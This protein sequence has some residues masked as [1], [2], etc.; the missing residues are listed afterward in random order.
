M[1][2]ITA[3]AA[4]LLLSAGAAS[5]SANCLRPEGFRSYTVPDNQTLIVRQGP[6]D[7]Y[8]IT[9]A[10]KCQSLNFAPAVGIKQLADN[11]CVSPGDLVVYTHG[12][13]EQRC[14]ITKIEPYAPPKNESPDDTGD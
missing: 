2:T 14:I 13:I 7:Q 5:A 6:N 12:G 4:L 8:K 3:A 1:K 11:M 10:I 9:L